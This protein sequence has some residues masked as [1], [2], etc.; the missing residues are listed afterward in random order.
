MDLVLTLAGA[1]TLVVLVALASSALIARFVFGVRLARQ[2]RAAAGDLSGVEGEVLISG[3]AVPNSP[4]PLLATPSWRVVH[5]PVD[6]EIEVSRRKLREILRPRDRFLADEIV[7]EYSIEDLFGLWCFGGRVRVS[8]R[9]RALPNPG[10]LAASDLESCLVSGDLI[11]HPLGAAKGDLVDQRPYTRSDPARLI[12]WK[13]YARS[14]ELFVRTPEPSRSPENRPLTYL[15]A[16]AE[17]RAAAATARLLV[18]SGLLGD[19]AR[20]AT[21]GSP[22]AETETG[23][24]LDAIASSVSHRQR[25]GGDLVAALEEP[26]VSPEDPV[27]LICPATRGSWTEI[28]L[29]V[30][31]RQPSRFLVLCAGDVHAPSRPSPAWTRWVLRQEDEAGLSRATWLATARLLATTG[32]RTV[33]VDRRS[34]EVLAIGGSAAAGGVGA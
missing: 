25:G 5:P 19:E 17:D 2:C 29:G 9:V 6:T 30:I 16:G 23:A 14:R 32:T 11:T 4:W 7:R 33:A 12:L 8:G 1:F 24:I 26:E 27:L 20:L 34:G 10:R 3:L 28:V 22:R 15:V 13:V 18:D 31:R 21:D